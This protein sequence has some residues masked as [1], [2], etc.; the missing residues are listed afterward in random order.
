M[1][2]PPFAGNLVPLGHVDD[3]DVRVGQF[4]GEAGGQVIAPRLDHD[5]FQFGKLPLEIGDGAQVGAGVVADGRVRTAPRLHADDPLQR[6]HFAAGEELG[7]FVRVDVVGD[8]GQIDFGPQVAAQPFDDGRF[9][10]ADRPGDA[11]RERPPRGAGEAARVPG[12]VSAAVIVIMVVVAMKGD[13]KPSPSGTA[14]AGATS[15]A[16]SSR[17]KQARIESWLFMT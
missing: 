6:E 10:R 12:P 7:V 13:A 14:Q 3:E 17:S 4:A 8:D 15:P 5:H 1:P 16:A 2:G 11:D 9:A